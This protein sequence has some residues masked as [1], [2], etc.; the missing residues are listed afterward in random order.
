M[1]VKVVILGST[2]SI[3][4]QAI[5]VATSHPDLFE[6][7]ALVAGTDRDTLERQAADLG[8]AR[9]GLGADEAED[10]A[11]TTDCDVVL[12]AIVGSAGLRASIAALES[13]KTLALANKE[14]LVTGGELCLAAARD[15]G[16]TIVPIDSEHAAIAQCL[17][18]RAR[19]TVARIVL[20]ASGGPFRDRADLTDV[21]VDDAL[22]H[23]TWSMGPKITVDSATLMNKGFEVIEGHFL[24]DLD[25]DHIDV[26]VHR[27]SKVHGVVEFVDGT[28]LLQAA[29]TDMRIPIQAALTTPDRRPGPVAPLDLASEGELTF[30]PVD[31]TRFPAV[32]LAYEAGRAGATFPAALNAA[33]EEAVHAFLQG[34]LRFVD[35]AAVVAAVVNE[36]EPRDPR[37]LDDVL[38]VDRLAREQAR[39]VAA[40]ASAPVGGAA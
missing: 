38:E 29:P 5:D 7:V 14:S 8:V 25:Y 32:D 16:G 11:R 27:Q 1:P 18:G 37:S 13:G 36:H 39:Y 35:I 15:G 12:N 19:D 17:E 3:G 28:S 40:R 6:V 2:G 34:D 10:V 20:T 31:R 30:E 4:R 26:V 9:T 22:A 23:P 21:T 24:F 33:N